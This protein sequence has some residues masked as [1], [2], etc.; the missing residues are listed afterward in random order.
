MT[1]IK[2]KNEPVRRHT[3]NMPYFSELFHDFFDNMLSNDSRKNAAPAVNI[4]ENDNNFKLEVAAPGL[5]KGDL[6]ISVDKDVLS[7]S[8]ERKNETNEKNERY[9]R[10]EFSYVSFNRSFNLP[11]FVD[12]ENIT[13]TYENGIMKVILPKKEEAKPKPSREIKVS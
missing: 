4:S 11:E 12:S 10:K 2:F 8:A 6:K 1:L 3:D 5:S 9:T 7:V 13:A